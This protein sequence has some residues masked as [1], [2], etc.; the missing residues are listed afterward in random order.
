[1]AVKQ[2]RFLLR[3]FAKRFITSRTRKNNLCITEKMKKHV[4][5][6]AVVGVA[7]LP[8]L[9]VKEGDLL[10]VK[11]ID[12]KRTVLMTNLSLFVVK[13]TMTLSL[14]KQNRYM[15]K[16]DGLHYYSDVMDLYYFWKDVIENK[17]PSDY[18]VE[19]LVYRDKD[20]ETPLF[21]YSDHHSHMQP[22][23]ESSSVWCLFYDSESD[24]VYRA[25]FLDLYSMLSFCPDASFHTLHGWGPPTIQAC[26]GDTPIGIIALQTVGTPCSIRNIYAPKKVFW[27]KAKAGSPVM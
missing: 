14:L 16:Q 12:E 8:W 27:E 7:S 10:N 21:A 19:L 13:R 1:M 3:Q 25:R 26:D 18:R 22:P 17:L 15:V 5:R 4:I 23:Q 9:T 20:D 24:T 2:V 11:H 6:D